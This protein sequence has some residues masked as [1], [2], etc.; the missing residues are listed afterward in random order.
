MIVRELLAM[1]SIG[2]NKSSADQ[3]EREMQGRMFRLN[4]AVGGAIAGFLTYQAGQWAE[5]AARFED[6]RRIMEATGTTLDS[7]REKTKGLFSD[8]ALV[9]AYNKADQFGLG[10]YFTKM[11][12]IADA[13]GRVFGESQDYML[14]RI[15][16]GL[17]KESPMR[18]DELGILIKRDD[19]YK[20]Y[21]EE[22]EGVNSKLT[23]QQRRQALIN[24]VLRQGQTIIEK[25][26]SANSN[27]GAR[28][29]QL[30]T[31][32]DGAQRAV[33]VLADVMFQAFGPALMNVLN[34][35]RDF[36]KNKEAQEWVRDFTQA[37]VNLSQ[38]MR[39]F[40]F[41]A[42]KMVQLFAKIPA[43]GYI[44]AGIIGTGMVIAFAGLIAKTQALFYATLQLTAAE[45]AQV[46]MMRTLGLATKVLWYTYMPLIGTFAAVA[47][48]ALVF[49]AAMEE[50]WAFF[51]DDKV[52]LLETYMSKWGELGTLLQLKPNDSG[53]EMFFKSL[54]FII[55]GAII[56]VDIFVK[57]FMSLMGILGNIPEA[58]TPWGS[59]ARQRMAD[60]Y[61]SFETNKQGGKD[62]WNN[63]FANT[64]GGIAGGPPDPLRGQTPSTQATYNVDLQMSF[65]TVGGSTPEEIRQQVSL[66]V[67]EAL[68]KSSNDAASN[69]L[70]PGRGDDDEGT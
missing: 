45:V 38:G 51:D 61:A 67:Q 7:L 36:E 64:E 63:F 4:T 44:V 54:L 43:M 32:V 49:A 33:G 68:E 10:Q 22:V 53:M 20:K 66:G 23:T 42:G 41:L 18:L 6:S 50:L 25:A 12:E 9:Q 40:L 58:L 57:D 28:Y 47:I 17:A 8:T 30:K 31:A 60:H 2:L 3:V 11:A 15:T 69:M 59:D 5:N 52:G 29:D 46:G 21:A 37:F 14:Q 34:R 56:A 27:M 19:L 26:N 16:T 70:I 48:G 39:P 13:A 55:N 62:Y 35:I 1:F 65:G 24:E